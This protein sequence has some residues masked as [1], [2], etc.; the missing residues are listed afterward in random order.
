MLLVIPATEDFKVRDTHAHTK[1]DDGPSWSWQRAAD[2]PSTLGGNQP[3]NGRNCRQRGAALAF[4]AA[5]AVAAS[6]V[7]PTAT[8]PGTAPQITP[9]GG[10]PPTPIATPRAAAAAAAVLHVP[11]ARQRQP[12]AMTRA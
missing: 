9:P 12:T 2:G 7:P 11:A 8:P 4:R 3:A 5:A 10:A 1:E 6:Q